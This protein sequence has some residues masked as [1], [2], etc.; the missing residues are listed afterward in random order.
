MDVSNQVE[1]R[2][3]DDRTTRDTMLNITLNSEA[4]DQ[5]PQHYSEILSFTT[6]YPPRGSE[7]PSCLNGNHV[8][9]EC[10]SLAR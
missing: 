5:W 9:G 2:Q 10:L 1:Q 4:G 8:E 7:M 6:P 3:I